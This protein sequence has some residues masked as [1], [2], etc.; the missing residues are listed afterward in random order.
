[1]GCP[2]EYAPYDGGGIEDADEG[3]ST[4]LALISPPMLFV[5]VV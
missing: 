1:M 5:V 2:S 3:A 4:L